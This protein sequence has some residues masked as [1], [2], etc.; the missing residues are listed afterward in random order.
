LIFD[1]VPMLHICRFFSGEHTG[2]DLGLKSK[3]GEADG[4]LLKNDCRWLETMTMD[5]FAR[6]GWRFSNMIALN[7]L[8][9][10][11]LVGG[12]VLPVCW[13]CFSK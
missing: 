2:S 8:V 10:K 1:K 7:Q 11:V 9:S 4:V 6:F 13:E 5:I 12:C 3:K